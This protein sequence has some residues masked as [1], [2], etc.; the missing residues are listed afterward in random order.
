MLDHLNEIFIEE[1]QK[2]G[3]TMERFGV[4]AVSG[5]CIEI[6]SYEVSFV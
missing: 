5:N 6:L 2:A 3:N 4:A 1:V